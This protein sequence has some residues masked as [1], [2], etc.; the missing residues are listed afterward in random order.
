MDY[1]S[2]SHS[3]REHELMEA[4]SLRDGVNQEL[5]HIETRINIA[6]DG[7]RTKKLEVSSKCGNSCFITP[8]AKRS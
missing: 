6:K 8:P 3:D 1:V 5:G 4:T 7:I 2:N